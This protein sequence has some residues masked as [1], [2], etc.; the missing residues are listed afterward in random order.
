MVVGLKLCTNRGLINQ[1]VRRAAVW[2]GK[3]EGKLMPGKSISEVRHGTG[4]G[5]F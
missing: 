1:D 5:T 2:R 4:R 3:E